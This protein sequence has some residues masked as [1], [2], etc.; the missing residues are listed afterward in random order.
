LRVVDSGLLT[1]PRKFQGH[2]QREAC[3][4]SLMNVRLAQ[5]R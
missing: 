2:P 5:E 3:D 1:V 4:N